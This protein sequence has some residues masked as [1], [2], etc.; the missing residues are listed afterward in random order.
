MGLSGDEMSARFEDLHR[1][2]APPGAQAPKSASRKVDSPRSAPGSG[3]DRDFSTVPASANLQDWIPSAPAS[4]ARTPVHF[5]SAL[6][7][8]HGVR[9]VSANNGIHLGAEAG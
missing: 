4:L 5:P 3:I 8:T 6:P 7:E 9:A 2:T 1:S